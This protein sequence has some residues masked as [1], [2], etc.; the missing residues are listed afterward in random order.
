VADRATEQAQRE[1]AAALA[2][3]GAGPARD[4][5]SDG[6][7]ARSRRSQGSNL[8][9]SERRWGY[10]LMSP[11]IIGLIAFVVLPTAAAVVLSFTTWDMLGAPTWVGLQN[12]S[13]LLHDTVFHKVVLNTV[14]YTVLVV[15]LSI[16]IGLGLAVL[17]NRH[18][19]GIRI[20]RILLFTPVTVPVVAAGLLW[21]W[22]MTPDY[23]MVNYVLHFFGIPRV[24]WIAGI[25]TAMPSIILVGVWRAVGLNIVLFLAALQG[26]DK[27][28]KEAAA[29]DG[30]GPWRTFWRI[31]FPLLTPTTFF[32]VIMA[33]ISSFQVFDQ[34]YVMTQGGP[35][36]STMT[37]IYYI[38][39][40][41]FTYL[42]MGYASAVSTLFAIAV[43]ILTLIAIKFQ[44]LWVFYEEG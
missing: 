37:V 4:S 33:V 7:R 38:F 10:T 28:I 32:A 30:A 6:R 14:Y 27:S 41:G 26:I 15:P 35:A 3:S 9:R 1:V 25:Q 2:A 20:F 17:L 23:G 34:T 29:L 40:Q 8:L 24:Q 42:R 18:A 19:K 22:I 16:G 21:A 5:S 31:T 36:N 44:R 12:Y 43:F 39:L 11:F 13:D